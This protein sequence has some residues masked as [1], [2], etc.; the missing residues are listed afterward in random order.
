ML[1]L[2]CIW[3]ESLSPCT[4]HFGTLPAFIYY[5]V[6]PFSFLKYSD[7]CSPNGKGIQ[8]RNASHNPFLCWYFEAV[9]AQAL[10]N[11]CSFRSGLTGYGHSPVLA[12]V[13]EEESVNEKSVW[14][15]WLWSDV[16]TFMLW[17]FS[18]PVMQ[19]M[20]LHISYEWLTPTIQYASFKKLKVKTLP[21]F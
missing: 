6:K 14:P 12:G 19:W 8:G 10:I 17:G 3:M 4:Y 7:S 20:L 2:F 11:F 21:I 18:S 9:L 15:F 16:A 5:F 13:F 1:Y